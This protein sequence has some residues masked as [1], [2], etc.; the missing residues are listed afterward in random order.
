LNGRT[1]GRIIRAEE[2]FMPAVARIDPKTVFSADEW[3]RLT[4]RSSLRGMFLVAHA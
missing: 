1:G 3:S 2:S 4:A